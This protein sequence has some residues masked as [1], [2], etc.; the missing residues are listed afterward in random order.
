[1]DITP[2]IPENRQIIQSYS[3]GQFKINGS[4]YD[5]PILILPEQTLLW[6]APVAFDELSKGHFIAPFNE[7][8]EDYH[9]DIL[10]LGTGETGKFLPPLLNIDLKKEG[11]SIESM[12]TG[13][14]CRT[15]NVLMAEGRKIAA[16]LLPLPRSE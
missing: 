9:I 13:A 12:N 2:L 6:D 16:F 5:Q 11:L 8:A 14:A 4:V 1:M 3:P 15:Y 7:L 10:L